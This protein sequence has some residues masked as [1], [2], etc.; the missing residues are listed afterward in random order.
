LAGKRVSDR[1]TGRRAKEADCRGL[2]FEICVRTVQV[3]FHGLAVHDSMRRLTA[4]ARVD[5]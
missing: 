3:H 2:R 4:H 5:S 1:I